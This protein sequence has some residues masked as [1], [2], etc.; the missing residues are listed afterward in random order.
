MGRQIVNECES[1]R[2]YR[3]CRVDSVHGIACRDY[4]RRGNYD[5]LRKGENARPVGVVRADRKRA[6]KPH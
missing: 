6:E 1:C 5:V 3:R 4:E 2:K